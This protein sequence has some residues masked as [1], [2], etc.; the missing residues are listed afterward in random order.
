MPTPEEL[1]SRIKRL[2][3]LWKLTDR[4][5]NTMRR[6]ATIALDDINER[7]ERLETSI[8]DHFTIASQ[9]MDAIQADTASLLHSNKSLQDQMTG[10]EGRMT[11]MEGRMTGLEGRMSAMEDRMTGIEGRMTG[12]EGKMTAMEDRI[13]DRMSALEGRM[14]GMEQT[15][16]LILG[17]LN[18]LAP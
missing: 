3:N 10:M 11:G 16:Q 8:T 9:R 18:K 4:E 7:F 15:L 13:S 17:K 14:S 2:E 5:Q 1:D 12:L 6:L